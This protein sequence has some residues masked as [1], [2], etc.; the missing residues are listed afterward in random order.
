[1][2]DNHRRVRDP[3][4]SGSRGVSRGPTFPVERARRVSRKPRTLPGLLWL[5]TATVLALAPY[6]RSARAGS[7][8]ME[9]EGERAGVGYRTILRCL[10]A[11]DSG[12]TPEAASRSAFF[13][14]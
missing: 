9:E 2:D 8:R 12:A 5:R 11:L 14:R 1:M 6:G 3:S 7:A 4:K 10:P 13:S